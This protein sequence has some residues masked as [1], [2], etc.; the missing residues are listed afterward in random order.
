MT[1]TETV[2]KKVGPI[3]LQ[4][5]GH[6]RAE[7]KKKGRMQG[8]VEGL[9]QL[10]ELDVDLE[11]SISFPMGKSSTTMV[12]PPSRYICFFFFCFFYY[13]DMGSS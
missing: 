10:Y 8:R 4:P 12:Q 9:K 6:R 3:F 1:S 7:G 5:I 11:D 13:L 2:E